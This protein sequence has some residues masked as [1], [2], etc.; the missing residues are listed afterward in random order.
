MQNLHPVR[1]RSKAAKRPFMKLFT[2]DYRDGTVQ[3]SFE[4]KGFYMQ[5]LTLLHDGERV[6]SDPKK[7]GVMMQCDPRAA[8][9]I[10]RALIAA[11]KLYEDNGELRNKRID[12]DLEPT[13]SGDHADF[14]PTSPVLQ[15]DI[16][17]KSERTFQKHE[18][19][20]WPENHTMEDSTSTANARAISRE[21]DQ[22]DRS[23][24]HAAGGPDE[25]AGL[26]GSTSLIVGTFAGWLNPY[27][28][29][30]DTARRV[31]TK[32]VAL[33]GDR[34]VRDGFAE[35]DADISDGKIRLPTAKMFFGYC[36]TA[37]ERGPRGAGS[38]D[39][40]GSRAMEI[41]KRMS[42]KEATA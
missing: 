33:Y 9:R 17:E 26:N 1:V 27:V 32:S 40:G 19:N 39:P 30:F 14:A 28:P 8:A 24:K 11:G 29:D 21:V 10:S 4:Q 18:S 31:I 3:L 5:V 23:E 16:S 20:Q 36:R 15:P 22:T 38:S 25:I 13:S 35:L 41:L 12:R 2:S 6:P 7:L 37:Q 34:S 42:A